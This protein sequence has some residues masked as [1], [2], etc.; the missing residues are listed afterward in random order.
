LIAKV[1]GPGSYR[2]QTLE[3]DNVSNSWNINQLCRF[4]AESLD[5]SPGVQVYTTTTGLF[6]V[7]GLRVQALVS[8]LLYSKIQRQRL[9]MDLGLFRASR[10]LAAVYKE[11]MYF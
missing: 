4:Y 8:G 1:T 9:L 2:L 7:S 10:T 5:Y 11:T 6:A 3:G